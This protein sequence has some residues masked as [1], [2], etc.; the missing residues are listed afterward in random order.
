MKKETA[1]PQKGGKGGVDVDC[2]K[3]EG[4]EFFRDLGGEKN[5]RCDGE[6]GE[7]KGGIFFLF[8]GSVRG[9]F[10]STSGEGS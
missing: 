7:G 2:V 8:T 1:H 6:E 10:S 3:K 4:E 9:S 5:C